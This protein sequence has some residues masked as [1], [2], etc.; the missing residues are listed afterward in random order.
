MEN[1]TTNPMS[2]IQMCLKVPKG[3]MNNFGGYKYR[4]CE[5][6]VEAV[7]PLLAKH[8]LSLN[9]SDEIIHIGDRYYVKATASIV[10]A[11]GEQVEFSEGWAREEETKKGMDASQITGAASSYA[12]KYALNGLLG[13]DDT[14]DADSHENSESATKQIPIAKIEV[15]VKPIPPVRPKVDVNDIPEMWVKPDIT[16][17]SHNI[18]QDRKADPDVKPWLTEGQFKKVMARIEGGDLTVYHN[19]IEQFKMKKDYRTSLDE[20]FKFSKSLVQ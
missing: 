2:D 10:N 17:P 15:D 6:I 19:T 20:I 1:K 12:R 8:G 4:S 3:Q 16:H 9:I 14:K 5:D 13:I 18:T 7:K 11:A